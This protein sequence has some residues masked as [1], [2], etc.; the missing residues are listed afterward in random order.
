MAHVASRRFPVARQGVRP[1][2]SAAAL[3]VAVLLLAVA[4]AL[5]AFGVIDLPD[6]WDSASYWR[7]RDVVA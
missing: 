7:W 2:S 4:V 6:P 1:L 3:S 5:I